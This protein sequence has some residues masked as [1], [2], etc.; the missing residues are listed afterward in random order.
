MTTSLTHALRPAPV[1]TA[2]LAALHDRLAR[3]AAA[4]GLL[5]VS[6]AI[7]SSP[8]GPL[9]LATTPVGLLRVAFEREDHDAVL[10]RIADQVSPRI[11]QDP[12]RL[13]EAARQLDEY[14]AGRRR[15]FTLSLDRSLSSGFRRQVQDHLPAIPYGQTETY[16]E[17]ATL[18]GRPRASRAVG[19]GCATN[20]LPVVLPCHRVLRSDGTLGGYAGGLSVKAM[21]LGLEAAA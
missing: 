9:L 14:F 11:L 16:A 6:Y 7:H 19:S 13:A 18:L 5:D 2:R 4:G 12:S 10:I 21:L 20:P 17:V 1:D 8:V 3:T 15:E